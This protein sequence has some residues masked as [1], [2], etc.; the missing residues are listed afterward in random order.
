MSVVQNTSQQT[1]P[2]SAS[3]PRSNRWLNRRVLGAGA[4]VVAVAVAGTIWIEHRQAPPTPTI[5]PTAP[6]TLPG[7]LEGL[8]AVPSAED[9]AAQQIWR[10]QAE[11]AAPGA[12]V[13]GRSYGSP[14]LHRQIRVVA[15]RAD[16]AGKLEFVW[17]GDAGQPVSSP[18]GA[19]RCTQSLRLTPHSPITVRPTMLMCWRTAALLSA[20][21]IVIDFDHQPSLTDGVTALDAA[22]RA[23][24]TAH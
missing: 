19:A 20:Y 16:L 10:Q 8:T 14:R 13:T 6:L 17:A 11:T 24:L 21:S 9:F 7:T 4:V 23:G 5:A 2:T 22:W 1:T 18:L 3:S 15:G 12:T